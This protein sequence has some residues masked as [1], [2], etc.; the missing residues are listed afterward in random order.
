MFTAK[1]L[2]SERNYPQHMPIT[3]YRKTT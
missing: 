1:V 3:Y 2:N